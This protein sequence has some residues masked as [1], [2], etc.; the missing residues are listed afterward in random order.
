MNSPAEIPFRSFVQIDRQATLPIYLQI[1]NQLIYAINLGKINPGVKLPGSRA[2]GSLLE[3][4]RNTITAV[5]DELY[6][7]GWVEIKPNQG[8]FISAELPQ[9]QGY[10]KLAKA[11][12]T[13][14][15]YPFRKSFLLES[16]FEQALCEY[17]LTD[18]TPDIRL[19]QVDDLSRFYSANIKR[20]SNQ[21]KMGYFQT[22]GSQYFKEQMKNYLHYSR[23]L[24]IDSK[25]ILITRSTEM[26]LYIIAEILLEQGD[27]V[28][29]SELSYFSANMIFQKS[30]SKIATVP[31]LADGLDLDALEELCK[32][33]PIRMVYV[34]PQ[35][36]YP[37]TI[38]HSPQKR[39]RLLQLA[40]TYGF[41]LVEDD[42]EYD[43]QYD[44]QPSLPL[45]S[46]DKAGMVIYVSSFGKSLAPGFRTGFIVGPEDI[47][48]EMRKHLGIIDRQGDILMEQA[49]GEMIEEGAIHR[50]LKRSLKAYKQRRDHMALQLSLKLGHAL[51]F[52]IPNG[53]LALWI[54]WKHPINLVKLA[55]LAKQRNLFIP[56][57][58][59]YQTRDLTAMR[60]G[61][62]N[63]S[64]EE[65]D[66]TVDILQQ[67]YEQLAFNQL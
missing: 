67:S 48:A 24:Q 5:Y 8:T 4:H 17:Q 53:G 59:L 31:L 51:D 50:H 10:K 28:V 22:D 37:T 66:K 44:K 7:Q 20:K 29:V 18:G 56:K 32:T 30:G 12:P 11:F 52:Q 23:G 40:S 25:N 33:Q 49:L 58:L 2:L 46:A 65:I 14:T 27:T 13:T 43:F 3:V 9:Q 1:A 41:V 62:G 34:T 42:H 36:H 60:I 16:P 47:M 61:F 54:R 21:S 45:I 15:G 64:L 57:T 63:L 38:N 39:M 35:H 55:H 19:T 26:S 6:A